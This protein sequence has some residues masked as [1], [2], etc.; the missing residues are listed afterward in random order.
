MLKTLLILFTLV[1]FTLVSFAGVSAT[2][3]ETD[4]IAG[5][6]IWE[7]GVFTAA[8]HGPIYPASS[9]NQ[10]KFLPVPFVIYRGEKIRVGDGSFVK[11][12]AVEKER[13]KLDISLGAAFNADSEDSKIREGMPDLDFM[14]E[15]GPQASFLL[16]DNSYS[17]TWL[18]LQLRSVFS[19]DF[20]TIN[21]RGYIFQPEVA[22]KGQGIVSDNSTL[23]LAIS[24][25]FA[26]KK[27]HQYF[28]DVDSQY[29]NDQRPYYQSEGGYLG[30]KVS[31]FNRFQISKNLSVFGAMQIGY[32]K[33]AKNE[34][35]PLHQ[36]NVTYTFAIGVKWTLAESANKAG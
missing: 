31:V 7:A 9:D 24:P 13:F 29:V 15:I 34:Q 36:Q 12:V 16:A 17:S 28:Y 8:F 26:S 1:S 5:K 3:G 32:W 30:S 19:S 10:H 2:M 6:P 25:I 33:G 4:N 23:G 21:Q 18:N 27:T 35:S 11:A 14:F 22:F 20:S